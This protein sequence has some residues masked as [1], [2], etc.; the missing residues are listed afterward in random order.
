M[1]VKYHNFLSEKCMHFKVSCAQYWPFWFK[2]QWVNRCTVSILSSITNYDIRILHRIWDDDKANPNASQSKH[3]DWNVY[4]LEWKS[5]R[6]GKSILWLMVYATK[7]YLF[8]PIY[9]ICMWKIIIAQDTDM[10]FRCQA[11]VR[12]VWQIASIEI[13]EMININSSH[14]NIPVMLWSG[15]IHNWS[16]YAAF[17]I[18]SMSITIVIAGL[19]PQITTK[20]NQIQQ[21]YAILWQQREHF[22]PP[23]YC[24]LCYKCNYKQHKYLWIFFYLW[25]SVSLTRL[26]VDSYSSKIT[27]YMDMPEWD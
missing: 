11:Q 12:C 7:A 20:V 25:S 3:L 19:L 24:S 26:S 27:C 6:C 23:I 22:N 8:H 10:I 14:A 2:P 5:H 13:I 4:L 21:I 18:S 9:V 16:R 15:C 1:W 17:G